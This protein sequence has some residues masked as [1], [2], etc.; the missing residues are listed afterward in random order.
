[1]G[2][3]DI[4]LHV[5]NFLRYALE[6]KHITEITQIRTEHSLLGED[7]YPKK[8]KDFILDIDLDFRDPKMGIMEYKKTI[9]ITKSLI[10]Q[11]HFISIA[12][13][14]YFLDQELAIRILHDL[15]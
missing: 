15:L 4:P 10:S 11:A 2:P 1:M 13:S 8:G 14:P 9:E 5:G 6:S 3:T 7:L 12:T